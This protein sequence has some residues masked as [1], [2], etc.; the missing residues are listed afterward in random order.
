MDIFG[1]ELTTA[2]QLV[3]QSAS[4]LVSNQADKL[5]ADK[6]TSSLQYLDYVLWQREWLQDDVLAKQLN[7]WKKQLVAPLPVLDSPYRPPAP[8][9]ANL[10]RHKLC[11]SFIGVVDQT[12]QN[13]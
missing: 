1:R 2:Y 6:L 3:S 13:S 4:Q 5:N 7:Y 12:T 11:L 8:V 9:G 10:S